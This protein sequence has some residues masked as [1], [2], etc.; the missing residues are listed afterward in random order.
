MAT[1][2]QELIAEARGLTDYDQTVLSDSEFQQVVD[3]CKEE[4]RADFGEPG[5]AFYSGSLNADRALFWFVCIAAKI[6]TGEIGGLNITTGD[7]EAAHPAQVHH[8]SA[9]FKNYENRKRRAMKNFSDEASSGPAQTTIS[10]DD[11]GY[12]FDPPEGGSG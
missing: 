11:R 7:V 10:R 8:D 12:E 3:I 4:L 5:Y 1:N 9:W 2:D 6:R